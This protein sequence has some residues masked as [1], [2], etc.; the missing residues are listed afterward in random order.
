M[1]SPHGINGAAAVCNIA[2]GNN[3]AV[4]ACNIADART[5]LML[6]RVT[7]EI[8]EATHTF[9]LGLATIAATGSVSAAATRQAAFQDTFLLTQHLSALAGV[10]TPFLSQPLFT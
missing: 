5:L 4:A 2:T 10:A 8:T 6:G 3:G 1:N 7:E 9:L